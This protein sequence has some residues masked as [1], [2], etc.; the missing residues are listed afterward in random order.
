MSSAPVVGTLDDEVVP[1]SGRRRRRGEAPTAHASSSHYRGPGWTVAGYV[2]MALVVLLVAVPLLWILITS[3]KERQDIYVRPAQWLP[4]PVTGENYSDVT[5]RIP[6]FAYFRNSFLITGV[7]SAAKIVLGVLSAYALA[8][9]R[10]PGRRVLFLVVIAAL[11]VP[12]QIT[13]ISNYALVAQL[14]WRNTYQGIIIPLAGVAFGTFL[15][16]NQFLNLPEEI[17][18]AARLDGA[19]PLKLLWRV[20]LPMSWPT[21]VAFSLI[22]VVNEWNEYLWPFL[23]SDD[24]RTAPLPVGLTLLQNN[25]GVTNWGPVMA[26]TVLAML[27]ILVL[28]LFLQRQMIKGL[29]A[30]AVKS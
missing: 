26:G 29:T 16:R 13:V 8:L 25:E 3:L 19:G 18:E 28:F 15:M 17:I 27:P 30:G 9:L 2:G 4:S 6:L 24:E 10:F 20:V 7:T 1:G 5:T 23:M 22:T 14:G 21:L 11:M 12:N